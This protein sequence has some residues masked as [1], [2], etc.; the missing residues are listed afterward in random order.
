MV[1]LETAGTGITANAVCPGWVLTPL[2]EKQI[3]DIAAQEKISL[4]QA[5]QSLLGQEQPSQ[6]FVGSRSDHR[7]GHRGRWTVDRAID[8]HVAEAGLDIFGREPTENSSFTGSVPSSNESH[9]IR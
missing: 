7:H 3:A 6:A 1:G 5:K 4:E 9:S 8:C 2:V